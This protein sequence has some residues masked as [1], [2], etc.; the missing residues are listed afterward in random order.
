MGI[1]V[2]VMG[3]AGSGKST[4]GL[5]LAA[6]LPGAVY[7]EGDELH[8]E[9]NIKKM[10]AGIPLGDA[11]R[12]PWFDRVLEEVRSCIEQSRFVLVGCSALKREYRDYLLRDFPGGRLLFLEGDFETIHRRMGR[13]EHFMPQALLES[14]FADLE[15]PVQG[16]EAFLRLSI[17]RPIDELVEEAADWLVS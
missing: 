7:L 4:V 6:R 16:E 11:D 3:V 17:D 9:G 8:P 5:R 10:S 12:Y 15:V 1:L 13:R 2:L 14:Q